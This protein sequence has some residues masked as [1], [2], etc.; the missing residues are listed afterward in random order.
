MWALL[1]N[2]V[3]TSGHHAQSA[4]GHTGRPRASACRP[5][6]QPIPTA[7]RPAA[8]WIG[9]CPP[10]PPSEAI[11]T[12]TKAASATGGYTVRTSGRLIALQTVPFSTGQAQRTRS[13]KKNGVRS[14]SSSGAAAG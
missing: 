11:R 14:R 1:P 3:A 10:R 8:S 9:R 13:G 4:T 12:R 5:S 6:S 7:P 2:S